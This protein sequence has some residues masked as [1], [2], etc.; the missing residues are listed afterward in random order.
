VAEERKKTAIT[1]GSSTLLPI[2]RKLET[3]ETTF[4]SF[5]LL[6]YMKPEK[7]TIFPITLELLRVPQ[8]EKIMK[9]GHAGWR[10]YIGSSKQQSQAGNDTLL[11]YCH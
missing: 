4:G 7:K 9:C 1:S 5:P 3:F 10:Q 8:E 2:R 11:M 6:Y